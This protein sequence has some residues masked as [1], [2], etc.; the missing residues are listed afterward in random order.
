M[1]RRQ[2]LGPAVPEELCRFVPSEW[3]GDVW[4]AYKAWKQA[5]KAWMDA[6]YPKDVI[7][8][9]GDRLDMLLFER[10]TRLRLPPDPRDAQGPIH[11]TDGPP[12]G[13][14]GD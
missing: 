10:D 4:T 6:N 7:G 2:R 11:W 13:Y 3:P 8:P 14:V 5:R 12:P 9:L 1:R